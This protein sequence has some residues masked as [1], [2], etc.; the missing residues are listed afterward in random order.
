MHAMARE[1][2]GL[3]IN[4]GPFGID[5]RPALIGAKYAE[6]QGVGDA[7]HDAVF[8]AYWQEGKSI[9]DR[10]VLGDIA[11]RVGM[12]RAAFL[13][14]LDEER[15]DEA[16]TADVYQAHQYGLTGVPALVFEHKYLVVGAQPYETLEQVVDKVQSE[17]D[18]RNE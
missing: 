1:L 4:E 9:E 5:S 18:L 6:A 12:D 8:R 11:Q 2:Y 17:R 15:W 16:V 3:E 10:E 7:Y 13:A 14:A